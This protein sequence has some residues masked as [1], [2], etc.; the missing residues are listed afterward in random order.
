MERMGYI[1]YPPPIK[2]DI[3]KQNQ[4]KVLLIL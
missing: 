1:Q 4:K 3:G 2:R